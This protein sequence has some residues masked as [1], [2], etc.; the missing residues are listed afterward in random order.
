V[1]YTDGL[2]DIVGPDERPFGRRRLADWLR[3]HADLSAA[4]LCTAL[5]SRLNAYRGTAEQYD[6]MTVLVVQVRS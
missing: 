5:F 1:L 4:E 2:T 6:D 3:S